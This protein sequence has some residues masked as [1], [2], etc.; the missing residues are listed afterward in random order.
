MTAPQFIMWLEGKLNE[1]GVEKIIPDGD[2][3]AAAYRRAQR[4]ARI[5]TLIDET[6]RADDVNIP[7]PDDLADRVQQILKTHPTLSW[8]EALLTL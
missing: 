4:I 7:V 5:Q 8:G 1:H 2:T 3:L 6:A